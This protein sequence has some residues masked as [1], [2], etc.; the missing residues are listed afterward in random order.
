MMREGGRQRRCKVGGGRVQV[1]ADKD[2]KVVFVGRQLLWTRLAML[3]VIVVHGVG[4]RR[5]GTRLALALAL[6]LVL[7][8]ILVLVLVLVLLDPETSLRRQRQFL[9]IY[10]RHYGVFFIVFS[11]FS[12][13]SPPRPRRQAT[14]ASTRAL[15]LSKTL[16]NTKRRAR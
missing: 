16:S 3:V 15:A 8:F 5:I 7:A 6:V 4:S 2:E 12:S 11:S 9:R 13:P 1:W 14:S 10:L